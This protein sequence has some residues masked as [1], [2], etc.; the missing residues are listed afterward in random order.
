VAVAAG[1][2]AEA[3]RQAR[4]A[5]V[6]LN[7]PPLTMLLSAQAAQLNGDEAAAERYFRAMLERRETEFLGLRGLIMQATKKGDTARA[8]GLARRAKLLRPKTEWVLATLYELE[9]RAG[10]WRS[11]G[12]T[13]R[14]AVRRGTMTAEEGVRN[15]AIAL[16]E[17]S[18]A[19]AA[20]GDS[21]AALG[22]ARK[23]LAL[24]PALI[25]AALAAAK[26]L[27]ESGKRRRA[28]RVIERAWE[29]LPHPAL[30]AQYLSLGGEA[31]PLRAR[32]GGDRRAPLGRGAARARAALAHGGRRRERARLPAVGGTRG[33]RAW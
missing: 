12:E 15:R 32:R 26:L 33:G 21:E 7:E 19:A 29:R 8:L 30:A 31:E 25:P 13:A 20:A 5:D 1:D 2:A 3:R 18:L 10:D 17:E 24:D 6:L 16:Y 9:A 27:R 4:R 28:E 23:A 11:A 22:A 14:L